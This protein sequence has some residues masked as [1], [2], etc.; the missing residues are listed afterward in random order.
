VTS[1]RS[2]RLR[3]DTMTTAHAAAIAADDRAGRGWAPD[4]PTEG[5]RLVAA[6]VLEAGPDYDED[7]PLGPLLIRRLDTDE[8]VGGVGFLHAPDEAG[9]VEIGY[10]LAPTA[11]GMGFATEAVRRVL[12]HAGDQGVTSVIALTTHDNVPSHRVLERCGF[13]RDGEVD[14][15]DGRL[16]RWVVRTTGPA[17]RGAA[18]EVT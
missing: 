2:A 5:D 3:L 8:V 9:A 6:L 14:T 1:L 16:L 17:E 10:G 13:Q 11:R 12:A 4:F 15:E 7:E 18:P